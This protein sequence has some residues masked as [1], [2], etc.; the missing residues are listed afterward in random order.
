MAGVQ[1]LD[2]DSP[3]ERRTPEKTR[4]DLVRV[5]NTT[6]GRFAVEPGWRCYE[7]I[8]PGVGVVR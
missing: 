1:S 8:K 7:C 4:I 3:D 6:I 2:F 5:G